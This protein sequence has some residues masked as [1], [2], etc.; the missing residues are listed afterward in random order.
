VFVKV[1]TLFNATEFATFSEFS[2]IQFIVIL[3]YAII[4]F[5]TFLAKFPA[6]SFCYH[7]ITLKLL[8]L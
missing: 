4:E 7:C 2:T 5:A 3:N 8:L 6:I 1:A